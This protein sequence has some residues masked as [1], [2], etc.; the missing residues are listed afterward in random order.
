MYQ[1]MNPYNLSET[2]SITITQWQNELSYRLKPSWNC[3]KFVRKPRIIRCTISS[4]NGKMAWLWES[5]LS[6]IVNNIYMEHSEKL[7]LD[8]AQY[9]LLLWLLCVGCKFAVWPHSAE[10]LQNFLS[11]LSSFRPSI[12]FTVEMESDSVIP[13]LDVLVIRRNGLTL[14]AKFYRKLA[15]TDRYIN[16]RSN[17]LPLV[18]RGLIQCSQ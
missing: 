1:S 5:S 9:K 4:S 11:H 7:A 2:S 17:H 18:K 12:Q 16:F 8:S 14:A 13:S 6:P 15:H 3:S 10:W